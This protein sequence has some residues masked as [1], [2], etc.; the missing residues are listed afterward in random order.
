MNRNISFDVLSHPLLL[1]P[2]KVNILPYLLLPLA[3]PED[4]TDEVRT[5]FSP[6]SSASSS[7]ITTSVPSLRRLPLLR[8]I[9]SLLRFSSL[10]LL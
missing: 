6:L 1:D 10:S 5:A 2:E 9:H 3:G 4:L 7:F 8:F